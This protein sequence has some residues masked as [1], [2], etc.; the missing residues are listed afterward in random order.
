MVEDH[1]HNGI[2]SRKIKTTNL[3]GYVDPFS[4]TSNEFQIL[5]NGGGTTTGGSVTHQLGGVIV[6][7]GAAAGNFAHTYYNPSMTVTGMNT[8]KIRFFFNVSDFRSGSVFYVWV[9]SEPATAPTKYIR[10]RGSG[11]G[12]MAGNIYFETSD[13]TSSTSHNISSLFG[14]LVLDVC[15]D[16]M[17]EIGKANGKQ[18]ARL[19]VDG[20]TIDTIFGT[21]PT[22]T[23]ATFFQLR[24][25]SNGSTSTKIKAYSPHALIAS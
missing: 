25:E 24:T 9:F 23:Y 11:T 15:K 10:L 18:F 3:D 14:T 5:L 8:F 7:S 1:D 17:I 4:L 21:I 12:V 19:S 13:G 6:D 2:N 22:F 16:I 20:T